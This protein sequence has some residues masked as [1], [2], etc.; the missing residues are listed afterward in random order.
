LT[1]FVTLFLR[2]IVRPLRAEPVRTALTVLA[3]SLGVAVV[4]AMDLAGEAAAGSF[5]SSLETL[6]GDAPLEIAAT[7]GVDE[8]LLVDLALRPLPLRF[9]PRLE[10]FAVVEPRRFV[11]PLVGVDLLALEP[12]PGVAAPKPG[13]LSTLRDLHSVWIS[14]AVDAVSDRVRLT[15]EGRTAEYTVRG[16]I[17][18]RT[19]FIV[20]DIGAAQQALGRAGRIDRIEV[21]P[22]RQDPSEKWQ[23]ALAPLVPPGTVVRPRGTQTEENRRMLSAFRWNLRVLSY[24][25]LV[26]GAFLI[27]NTISVSVV[28]RRPEIGILRAL[29][30]TRAQTRMLFLAEAFGMG[31]AGSLLGVAGGRLMAAGAVELLAATVDSLYVSSTPGEIILTPA[32]IFFAILTGLLVSLASAYAPAREASRIPPVEA[33]ARGQREFHARLH[34]ARD[35]AASAAFALAAWLLSRAEPLGGK[36]VGGYLACLALVASSALAIPAAVTA[37]SRSLASV[38]ARLFGAPGSLAARSILASLPR[39]AVLTG[40]LSTAIAMMVSVGLMVGS[41]RTTVA[42]WMSDQLQAD[43]YLRPVGGGGAGRYPAFDAAIADRIGR[44]PGVRSV[45]RFRVYEISYNGVPAFLGGGETAVVRHNGRTAFLPGQDRSA[46]LDRL[47]TGDYCI[48]SEPFANK[49]KVKPGDRLSL[50][51]GAARPSFEVLGVY[52][53]Y[54]S[55]RG[56]VIVD[57]ATLLRYLPDPNPSSLAVYLDAAADAPAVR[58]AVEN[59]A[60]PAMLVFS[61]ASLRR[62]ALRIFDRTFAIAWALEAVAILVAVLGVS[63]ALLALVIDRRREFGLLKYLGASSAQI[64]RMVLCEAGILGLLSLAVGG[65]LGYALSLILI[66]VINLQSFGW[67][68]QFHWPVPLLA[69]ALGLIFLATLLAGLYPARIAVRLN[70]VEVIHEE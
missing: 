45:D 61:N 44:V 28:R 70:P 21:Y 69:G 38:A 31:L 30:A 24:I 39:T 18:G 8:K 22:P 33:M 54:S 34:T 59:A 64:R 42:G 40:A 25:S 19:A 41:F 17:P 23:A 11:V 2:L 10:G 7:G 60:G 63:G 5:R 52:Y 16:R 53:D 3:V 29:G 4:V 27:F 9:V 49:H 55:E 1:A 36:P 51:L 15:I 20:M 47:P 35:L 14:S 48:V 12:G 32:S 57:R 6:S 62:E 37:A 65:V 46:I 50:P 58:R 68:I 66:Y 26:V 13:D 43:L 67:T 56:Y